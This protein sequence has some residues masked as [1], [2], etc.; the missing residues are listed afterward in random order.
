MEQ[1]KRPGGLTALA[2]FNFIFAGMGVLGFMGLAA[3]FGL[4]DMIPTD[5]MAPEDQARFE[6]FRDMGTPLFVGLLVLM[7]VSLVLEILS[8]I[9]YLKQKR[10]MG[11]ML[12]NIYA[13][14]SGV[15]GVASG[16]LMKP[17]LGGGFNLAAILGFVYP[18]LTLFLLNVTFKEDFPN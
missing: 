8:G 5:D 18:V 6:A 9:G 16:M 10:G 12:G 1:E 3:M 17:E 11:W 13:V 4:G 14:F 15:S 2:I 7:L